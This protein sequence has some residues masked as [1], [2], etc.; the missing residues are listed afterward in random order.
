[1]ASVEVWL[2]FAGTNDIAK[3]PLSPPSLAK[4]QRKAEDE[5]LV[6]NVSGHR[7][8][9]WRSTLEKYPDTL[10]GSNKRE[11]FFIEDTKEY[12][13]DRN[14]GIFEYILNYYQTGKLHCPRNECLASYDE[15]LMFFGVLP[16][17]IDDCCYGDYQDQKRENAERL[18]DNKMLENSDG[19]T[20]PLTNIRQRLW[21]A[22]ENPHSSTAALIFYYV[23][24]FSIAVAVMASIVETG[25]QMSFWELSKSS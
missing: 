20:L 10:L 16:D 6:I 2:P 24:V 7:F 23:T 4:N 9:T 22:F 8:E 17:V 15:E 25:K 13:F 21:H 14:A 5:K 11:L 1:M 3:N 19:N 18:H 12:F